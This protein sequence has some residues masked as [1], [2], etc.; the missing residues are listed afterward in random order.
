M[1]MALTVCGGARAQK[2]DKATWSQKAD[3]ATTLKHVVVASNPMRWRRP[4]SITEVGRETLEEQH[5]ESVLHLNGLT[6]RLGNGGEG[7]KRESFTLLNACVNFR[8]TSAL[9]LWMRG[10]NLL[11]QR[12][13]YIEGFPMPR[14]TVMAG[15]A[16]RF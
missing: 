13:E 4:Q 9:K 5:R 1:V 14:A 16:I 11:A 12:Y 2:A 6:T 3:S 10:E 15:A 7:D 8:A